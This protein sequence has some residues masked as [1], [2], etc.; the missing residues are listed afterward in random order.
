MEGVPA[1]GRGIGTRWFLKT[2]PIQTILW[3][4]DLW[5]WKSHTARGYQS[6]IITCHPCFNTRHLH[7][8]QIKFP[9]DPAQL[10]LHSKRTLIWGQK[11]LLINKDFYLLLYV[12]VQGENVQVI[13]FPLLKSQKS[14]KIPS[15]AN[16]SNT[17]RVTQRVGQRE[18]PTLSCTQKPCSALATEL[19]Q[20]PLSRVP[21]HCTPHFPTTQQTRERCKQCR[22]NPLTYIK[23]AASIDHFKSL[24][25][26]GRSALTLQTKLDPVIP[27]KLFDN[28]C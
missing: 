22:I 17:H 9:S 13:W 10:F 12:L 28:C 18:D 27:G 5:P 3:F 6:S 4:Y 24:Q 1:H 14:L 25:A 15:L 26:G 2:L 8:S 19:C 11:Y 21:S 20:K 23:V 16:S 7:S